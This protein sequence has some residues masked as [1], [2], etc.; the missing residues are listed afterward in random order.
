VIGFGRRAATVLLSTGPVNHALR[1]L[2]RA[3]G[4]RLVLVY[5]RV[6]DAVPRECEL[7][8]TLPADLFRAQLEALREVVDLV[9]LDE[10]LGSDGRVRRRPLARR[11]AVALTFDD[12][13][14]SHTTSVLPVLQELAIPA[15]FFLSGRAL[16]GLG[17]YWFQQLEAVLRAH[18]EARTASLL[19]FKTANPRAG[20]VRHCE[21]DAAV[22]QS[23]SALAEGLPAPAILGVRDV[24][25][26]GN[27]GMTIGFHT[28]DHP[29]LPVMEQTALTCAVNR[30]R[31]E[32]ARAA[33]TQVRYFAYP[34]GEADARTAAAVAD[35]GFEAAFTGRPEPIRRR[36]HR[37]RLGRWEPGPLNLDDLI[38][39]LAVRLHRAAPDA[40]QRA[41]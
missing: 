28:L 16:H 38:V 34:Y 32:L 25:A 22:R 5:H 26:L 41:V 3:R 4:H 15:A 18:G 20:W 35:A 8:P 1:T 39:K 10:I 6:G 14:P 30:G 19:G 40:A 23:I 27:A 11:P 36:S 37:Y 31:D 2:A 17:P 7:I 29:V 21:G 9:A 33:G 12:D 13:L 24:T